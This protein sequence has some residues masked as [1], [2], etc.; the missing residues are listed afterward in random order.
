MG[1][2]VV[3]INERKCNICDEIEDEFHC[4]IKCPKFNNE[5]RGLLTNNLVVNQNF[6]N[7]VQFFSSNDLKT[8]RKL[9]LLCFKIIKE[10]KEL[11]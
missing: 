7:F 8:Q 9:A 10:Y 5:R 3:N 4:L 1:P 11:L 2:N 6:D